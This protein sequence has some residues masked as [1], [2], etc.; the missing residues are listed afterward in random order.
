MWGNSVGWILS[1]V[2]AV[3]MGA[4]LWFLAA[5]SAPTPPTALSQD[6]QTFAVIEFPAPPASAF[7]APRADCDAGELYR[8]AIEAY[9]A[10]R[11]IYED[12]SRLG[13]L[14][15]PN[16]EKLGAIDLLVQ[17]ARCNDMKLFA[18]QPKE[19]INYARS[20]PA[21]EALDTLGKVCVDRLGLLNQ[22]AENHDLAMKYYQAGLALGAH[23]CNERLTYDELQLG[24]ELVSKSSAAMARVAEARGDSDLAAALRNYDAQRLS[25]VQQRI[26]PMARVIRSID[27]K[28]VGRHTGDVFEI[29]RRS[30]E[31][32]WRVEALL[33]AGRVRFFVGTGGTSGNQ[34]LAN[35]LLRTIAEADPDP[36]I[37]TAAA[38]ARYLTVEEHRMQ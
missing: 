6:P 11:T 27:P 38:T 18:T 37:R 29:A 17:A 3:A 28:I 12:F 9:H 15:S 7:P 35:E 31:R 23:L 30:D 4:L 21:L 14:K 33:A 20:R 10:N 36:T 8:Q 13:T 22:R 32:L 26:H 5:S 2:I 25:Y 19:L 16:I 1:G 34:R 24:L